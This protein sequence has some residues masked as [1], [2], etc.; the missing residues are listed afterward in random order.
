MASDGDRWRSTSFDIP[1]E[2]E[3]EI[4]DYMERTH[5]YDHRSEM[6]RA[7]I[8]TFI[9]KQTNEFSNAQ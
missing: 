2:L 7:A 8:R 3:A 9:A 6:Y 4:E 5:L 1:K